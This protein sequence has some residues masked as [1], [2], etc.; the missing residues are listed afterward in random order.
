MKSW[1][2]LENKLLDAIKKEELKI[3]QQ[4]FQV[5]VYVKQMA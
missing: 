3:W 2:H 1:F 5:Q 4:M